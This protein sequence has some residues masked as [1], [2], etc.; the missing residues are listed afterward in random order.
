MR[1]YH[2]LSYSSA[3]L[4]KNGQ[5]KTNSP[6]LYFAIDGPGVAIDTVNLIIN[7]K[8]T[9]SGLEGGG[10]SRLAEEVS[11]ILSFGTSFKRP[12]EGI[13]HNGRVQIS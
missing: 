5:I 9:F 13:H 1:I 12:R 6:Y 3:I 10:N 4:L 8:P 2:T 11:Q 7:L